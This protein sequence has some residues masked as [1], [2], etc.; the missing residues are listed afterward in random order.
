MNVIEIVLAVATGLLAGGVH[1]VSGPDHM[2]AVLPFAVDAPKR[3]LRL[4]LLWGV[5]H[6]VGVLVLGALFVVLRQ[7]VDVEQISHVA[8]GLVGVLLVVLGLWAL[9]RSRLVVVHHHPHAHGEEAPAPADHHAHPHVHFNDP[10]VGRDGH[11][12]E[13][14][15]R[16]HH[17]STVG[18]GFIHG[19]AG[20]G[21]L[22]VASPVIA[23]GAWGAGVYLISYLVGGMGAMTAFAKR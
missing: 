15:H 16:F 5:G 2:A 14:R 11:I 19:L 4:G 8:E 23:L 20:A 6:G 7:V 1:V 22:V 21:H 17:H 18:F 3:A 13:G 9:H 12:E 10:T